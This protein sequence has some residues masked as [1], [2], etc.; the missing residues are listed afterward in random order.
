MSSGSQLWSRRTRVLLTVALVLTLGVAGWRTG[1]FA[2]LT[3][4][5]S[6]THVSVAPGEDGFARHNGLGVALEQV[7]IADPAYTS[8]GEPWENL[9]GYRLWHIA[10]RVDPLGTD[11]GF[12]Q[13]AVKIEDTQGR[14]IDASTLVPSVEGYQNSSI[15]CAQ[16]EPDEFDEAPEPPPEIQQLLV[17]LPDD[18]E[19]RFVRIEVYA[20]NPHFL[21][22]PVR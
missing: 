18:A 9:E 17:S 8:W 15:A 13:C 4:W 3:W 14:V 7:A 5:P 21:Q 10:V 12:T 16:A 22:L 1:E 6:G 20:F 19:P 2:R 11:A